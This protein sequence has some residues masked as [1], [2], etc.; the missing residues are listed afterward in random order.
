MNVLRRHIAMD[1]GVQGCCNMLGCYGSTHNVFEGNVF[2]MAPHHA[3]RFG[4]GKGA[5]G[6][7]DH[8]VVRGN[9]FCNEWGRCCEFAG[10]RR[11]ARAAQ[12][13]ASQIRAIRRPFVA[14]A[15]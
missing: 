7:W 8:N 11:A 4:A 1:N 15:A 14:G 2:E 13:T 12:R 10:G 9:V 3:C 5:P 6:G